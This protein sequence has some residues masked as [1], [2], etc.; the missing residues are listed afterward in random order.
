[1]KLEIHDLEKIIEFEEKFSR[2]PFMKD[3]TYNR[4]A[5]GVDSV[6]EN[7]D[8]SNFL[9]K[10]FYH[11]IKSD[12]RICFDSEAQ[13][14]ILKSVSNVK[15]IVGGTQSTDFGGKN[16]LQKYEDR[17][18][19]TF[20]YSAFVKDGS[21]ELRFAKALNLIPLYVQKHPEFVYQALKEML[22]DHF[23]CINFKEEDK[24]PIKQIDMS[25]VK[26][27]FCQQLKDAL[28]QH[29]PNV[30]VE[31]DSQNIY[32]CKKKKEL[33][34]PLMSYERAELVPGAEET[35]LVAEI[36][37]EN[38]LDDV[39]EAEKK[40]ILAFARRYHLVPEQIVKYLKK[41]DDYKLGLYS[42]IASLFEKAND[43]GAAILAYRLALPEV[44]LESVQDYL[45]S[46][47]YFNIGK[48]FQ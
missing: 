41:R 23:V 36:L 40:M 10:L 46:T 7:Q 29:L 14:K 48:Y 6:I 43:M 15:E 32:I 37:R 42:E 38:K 20:P 39:L 25:G 17:C 27:E 26:T 5:S 33:I 28:Q 47:Q 18:Q 3:T 2:I 22:K 45:V 34:F 13:T 21:I 1:M 16:R 8:F 30:V 44:K 19:V 31:E 4:I 35:K 24:F 12:Y 9:K 11:V